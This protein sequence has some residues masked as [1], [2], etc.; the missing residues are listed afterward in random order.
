MIVIKRSRNGQFYFVVKAT[1]GRVLV[2][3]ETYT[4][5]E[6]VYGGIAALQYKMNENERD[7][8]IKDETKK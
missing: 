5:K 1:N 8:Q 6:N 4:R 3:S 7:P 2:T